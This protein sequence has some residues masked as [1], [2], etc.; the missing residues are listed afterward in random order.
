MALTQQLVLNL[1]PKV[2]FAFFGNYVNRYR[3]QLLQKVS[4]LIP[5][6]SQTS[7]FVLESAIYWPHSGCGQFPQIPWREHS[8][9]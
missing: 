1:F 4:R 9:E 3:R 5:H 2:E 7:S 6:F 8:D